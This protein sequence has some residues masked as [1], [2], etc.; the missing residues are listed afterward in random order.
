MSGACD[1]ATVDGYWECQR[2][3]VHVVAKIRVSTYRYSRPKI[4]LT[5]TSQ[6]NMLTCLFY[7][8]FWHV[9][10]DTIDCRRKNNT[11]HVKRCTWRLSW[12]TYCWLGSQNWCVLRGALCW[13][14]TVIL[15][16]HANGSLGVGWPL[17]V[18]C[19]YTC[20]CLSVRTF[21]LHLTDKPFKT[22]NRT[23]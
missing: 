20:V 12:A 3:V 18:V 7:V 11:E 19:F 21:C 15:I 22:F 9:N 8:M 17:S 13:D 1:N 4:K 16:I 14:A 10:Y 6:N 5:K 23:W 2:H